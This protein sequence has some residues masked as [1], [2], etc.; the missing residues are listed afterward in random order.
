MESASKIKVAIIADDVDRVGM[1]SAI[2]L[3][4]LIE[5]YRKEFSNKLDLTLICKQGGC[6]HEICRGVR[7]LPVRMFK[8]PKFSGFFSYLIFFIS[9]PYRFDVIHFP[10]PSLHPFFW[11]LKVFRKAGKIVV[12]FHGAPDT[13]NI[14]IF[15]TLMN[16]VNRWNI[17]LIG[18]FFIDA[19]IADSHIAVQQVASYYK[20]P[21][22]KIHAVYLSADESFRIME[23]EEK[24]DAEKRVGEICKIS[25]PY[26]LT[27]ARLDPHKNIHRLIEAF[28]LLKK[29]KNIPHT[30]LIVGGKH[31]PAY[32]KKIEDLI[33]NSGAESSVVMAPFIDDSDMPS[34]YAAADLFVFV[35][36]SEGFGI[37][38]IEAMKT[39]VPVVASSV[40][41]MPEVAG[42]GALLVNPYDITEI[43]RGM[44]TMLFDQEMRQRHIQK[45]SARG[46]EFSWKRMAAENFELYESHS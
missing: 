8:L 15:Q 17:I 29:G 42:G 2:V 26:I 12:T 3:R 19:C 1:G 28:L 21:V 27:V 5:Q 6:R 22:K 36:L 14:P 13:P 23:T 20:I 10:R 37:P 4:R 24:A 34:V 9:A 30:L 35:S 41:A 16:Y 45:G 7:M 32:S 31:D 39:G 40:S 43:G 18:Q 33:R 38:L 11:F 44:E 46:Q 25:T